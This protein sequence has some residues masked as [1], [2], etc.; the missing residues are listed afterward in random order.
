LWALLRQTKRVDAPTA[1]RPARILAIG[2]IT[3]QRLARCDE[4]GFDGAA[5]LGAVWN[6]PDPARALAG[7]RNEAARLEKAL[8]G[9]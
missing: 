3:D 7:I 1:Q 5:V 4:I 2:G 6:D 9:A 8:N